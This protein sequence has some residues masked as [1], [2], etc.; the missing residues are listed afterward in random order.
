[1][2]ARP[3]T[4]HIVNRF[5]RPTGGSELRALEL[6]RLLRTHA[7]VVLWSDEA[8]DESV[9]RLAPIR[10]I[11]LPSGQFPRSGTIVFV[12]AYHEYGPWVEHIAPTRAIIVYNTFHP[13]L[14]CDIH[15]RLRRLNECRVE[16]VYASEL[17]RRSVCGQG[18][19]HPSPIDL[20]MFAQ[21]QRAPGENDALVVGRL[22]R[23]SPEKHHP[24]DPSFYEQ[25]AANGFRLRLMGAQSLAGIL[26]DQSGI[27]L[28]PEG[29]IPA[30]EFLQSL[31]IFFYRTAPAWEESYGRVILEA[32]ATGLPVVAERKG[33]YLEYVEDGRDILLFDSESEAE[34]LLRRLKREPSLRRSIG[35][36]ARRTA[37]R[38]Y[39]TQF[40]KLMLDYYVGYVG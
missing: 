36:A 33:G 21:S 14:L 35:T 10:C 4:I 23:D 39:D 15:W 17:L 5:E 30:P 32:M 26:P 20:T 31:D 12:G 18:V 27:E 40:A 37:E 29:R 3:S 16:V 38:I 13:G 7:D 2:L 8:V 34:D 11:D 9:S 1:M 22:S 25:L 28:L 24:R 19:V 6:F